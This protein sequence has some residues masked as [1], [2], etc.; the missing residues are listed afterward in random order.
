[1][2][3]RRLLNVTYVHLLK[4]F[5]RAHL[6]ELLE[7]PFDHELTQQQIAQRDYREAAR[8]IGADVGQSQLMEAFGM[9]VAGV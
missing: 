5:E 9:K 6:D 8:A 4:T 1:M 3:M 2:S 7:A